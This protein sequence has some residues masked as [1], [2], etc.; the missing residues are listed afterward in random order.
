M[1]YVLKDMFKS[2]TMIIAF[3]FIIAIS[4]I[5][6]IKNRNLENIKIINTNIVN[7]IN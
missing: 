2:K 3:I 4:Y 6:G 5:G 1:L 7:H